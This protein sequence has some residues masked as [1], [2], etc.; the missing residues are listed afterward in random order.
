MFMRRLG[1]IAV[2]AIVYI[3]PG[4]RYFMNDWILDNILDIIRYLAG[5]VQF[6]IV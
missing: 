5:W 4:N 6:I 1:G 3:T 2:C